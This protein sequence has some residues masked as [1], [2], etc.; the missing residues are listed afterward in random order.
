MTAATT[1]L[2]GD[3]RKLVASE[4]RAAARRA[5]PRFVGHP[6]MDYCDKLICWVVDG[7]MLPSGAPVELVRNT[8]RDA[9]NVGLVAI[10][11]PG[12]PCADQGVRI[13]RDTLS[14]PRAVGRVR[15]RSS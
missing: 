10:Y 2:S 6:V 1:C 13:R 7:K 4:A 15:L 11:G 9:I 3:E 14:S 8:V 5:L 12:A